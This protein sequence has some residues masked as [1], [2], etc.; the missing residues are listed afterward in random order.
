MKR[1]PLDPLF[2]LM[3]ETPS[4]AC[5]ILGLS[6]STQQEYRTRGVTEKV[7]DRLAAKAG[8]LAYEV[9]PEMVDDII[10]SSEQECARPDCGNRFIPTRSDQAA[11]SRVCAD[12]LRNRRRRSRADV[13]AA[14]RAAAAR[15]YAENGDYVRA[16]RRRRYRAE[17]RTA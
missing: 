17:R 5:K 14:D 16:E 4:Q 10:G 3:G 1:Y 11:C 8:M 12:W 15:Y 13:R 6:G 2:T 7:A 9:W